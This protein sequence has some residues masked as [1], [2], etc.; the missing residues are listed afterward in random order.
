MYYLGLG[1]AVNTVFNTITSSYIYSRV[2]ELVSA[3]ASVL[4]NRT[5]RPCHPPYKAPQPAGH[6]TSQRPPIQA[7]P[8]RV[9][10]PLPNNTN[11]TSLARQPLRQLAQ[12]KAALHEKKLPPVQSAPQNAQRKQVSENSIPVKKASQEKTRK[13][14]RGFTLSQRFD[15]KNKPTLHDK[16]RAKIREDAASG[17]QQHHATNVEAIRKT[18]KESSFKQPVTSIQQPPASTTSGDSSIQTRQMRNKESIAKEVKN[19]DVSANTNRDLFLKRRKEKSDRSIHEKTRSTLRKEASSG[20]KAKS[21]K[22][23]RAERKTLAETRSSSCHQNPS[24]SSGAISI[25]PANKD[26]EKSNNICLTNTL[27]RKRRRLDSGDAKFPTKKPCSE[28]HSFS[29]QSSLLI[30]PPKDESETLAETPRAEARPIRRAIRRK[31]SG[32]CLQRGSLQNSPAPQTVKQEPLRPVERTGH[33]AYTVNPSSRKN[34]SPLLPKSVKEDPSLTIGKVLGSGVYGRVY[35]VKKNGKPFAL[36]VWTPQDKNDKGR[37]KAPTQIQAQKSFKK[38][39]DVYFQFKHKNI[40]GCEKAF[41]DSDSGLCDGL[42]LE[43]AECDLHEKLKWPSRFKP[44]QINQW[45]LDLLEGLSYM[46]ANGIVHRDLRSPNILCMHNGHLKISDFGVA[47]PLVSTEVREVPKFDQNNRYVA[48]EIKYPDNYALEGRNGIR[49]YYNNRIDIYAFGQI[50]KGMMTA[51]SLTERNKNLLNELIA[52]ST[53]KDP[54]K[55]PS[56]DELL[57]KYKPLLQRHVCHKSDRS[58]RQ[59]SQKTVMSQIR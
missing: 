31:L 13:T 47:K 8:K 52:E 18:R 38:E 4:F 29:E 10:Q 15:K 3:P 9:I 24:S 14:E 37:F 2:Q 48:P 22:D 56:A 57:E 39:A 28:N 11:K 33:T 1:S 5:V 20:S 50:V 51:H 42:L 45:V 44:Q 27:T 12:C 21:V 6:Y 34:D 23:I 53:V 32:E 36:K 54:T 59:A 25:Q 16:V 19:E 41:Y 58:G 35:Q 30:K 43:L 17:N 7:L 46:H 49:K 40:L 26:T 55:R